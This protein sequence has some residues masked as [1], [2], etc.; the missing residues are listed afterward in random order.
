MTRRG[1]VLVFKRGTT[2]KDAAAALEKIRDVLDL[3]EVTHDM[4][5]V[6]K[7]SRGQSIVDIKDR[8]FEMADAIHEFDD[9]DGCAGPVWYIP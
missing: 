8:Q 2:S 9:Y 3:P 7:T 4:V 6:G 1:T 5:E